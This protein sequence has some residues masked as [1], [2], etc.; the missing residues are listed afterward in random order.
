MLDALRGFALLGIL[1]VNIHLMRGP[2]IWTKI[3]GGIAE[4]AGTA[5]R[6][7]SA[8][9]GWLASG[10]FISSFALLFGVGAAVIAGRAAAR[11]LRP[12]PLLARRYLWL[13]AFGLAHMVLLF[14]GDVLFLYGLSGLILLAFVEVQPRTALRWGLGLIGGITVITA[15]FSALGVL[16]TGG[17]D[18]DAAADDPF[19]QAFTDFAVTRGEQA[20]AAF[21]EGSYLD[22]IVANAWQSLF[23]QGASLFI[24]PWVLGLFLLGFAAGKAGWVQDLAARRATLERLALIG[25]TVGLPLNLPQAAAGALGFDGPM[26]ELTTSAAWFVLAASIAQLVGAPLLAVGYL[27]VLALAFQRTRAPGPL[28]AV[29]RMALTAYLA[30]S[31]LALVVFAGFG[32]YGQVGLAAALWVVVGIWAV[33]LVAC[34]L[35]LR[36][37]RMGP[38]EWLWRTLTYG[39]GQP[40]RR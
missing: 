38:V 12:R 3:G 25:I 29:G 8:L 37:F 31:L 26:A 35:W 33:L 9:T 7:V 20:L 11:G 23:V 24:L 22:V 21:T 16:L 6:V 5:D 1:L 2:E 27:S 36:S 28:V 13:L 4:P 40:L 18:L 30:Q 39:R 14:P 34:P 17:L 10:K 15:G 19:T 32:R